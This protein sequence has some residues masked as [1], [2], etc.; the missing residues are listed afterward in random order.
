MVICFARC[1]DYYVGVLFYITFLPSIVSRGVSLIRHATLQMVTGTY[2]T[3]VYLICFPSIVV[4]L[5]GVI[6]PFKINHELFWTEEREYI[7]GL[8]FCFLL[9]KSIILST[10]ART[11]GGLLVNVVYISTICFTFLHFRCPMKVNYIANFVF[12]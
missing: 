11:Q 4:S 7:F 8:L 1:N 9:L 10:N 2:P 3:Y 5:Y 6:R 12:S